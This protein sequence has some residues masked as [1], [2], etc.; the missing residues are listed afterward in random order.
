M[1]TNIFKELKKELQ[2]GLTQKEH[3]FK[4]FTLATVGL[5]HVARLRSIVLREFSDDFKIT[6]FTDKRSKKVIH[7]K[8]NNKVSLLFF[9]PQKMIQ[10][11]IEGIATIIKDDKILEAYWKR[12]PDHLKKDYTTTSAPG[13]AISDNTNIEYLTNENHFCLVSIEA[14]KIEYLKITKPNHLKIRYSK[15]NNKWNGEFLVP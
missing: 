12:T 13:S 1:T 10:L 4:Y 11:K 7:I 6:F 15:E 8:E 3:P 14:K 5:D 9:H 2:D